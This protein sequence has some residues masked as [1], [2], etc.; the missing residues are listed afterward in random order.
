MVIVSEKDAPPEY[1]PI[2]P[3][4]PNVRRA[5]PSTSV[6][7]ATPPT[8]HLQTHSLHVQSQ[9][10]ALHAHQQQSRAPPSPAR[11]SYP[12]APVPLYTRHANI[13]S[14][15]PGILLRVVYAGFPQPDSDPTFKHLRQTLLWLAMTL[16]AVSRSF[17]LASMHVLRSS[18]LPAYTACVRKLYS[19]DP[20]PQ[21]LMIAGTCDDISKVGAGTVDHR[22]T[23]ILDRWLLLKVR[24]DVLADE[25]EL[26]LDL[27]ASRDV[28]DMHQPRARLEDLVREYG[29][30]LGVVS[31]GRSAGPGVYPFSALSVVFEPRRVLLQLAASGGRRLVVAEV[32]RARD[33]TLESSAKILVQHLAR[34]QRAGHVI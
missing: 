4:H 26:H 3:S 7:Q 33:E 6:R 15:P 11:S 18:Y 2:D 13:T 5:A 32:P 34:L 24:D 23:A 10:A 14:L 8:T 17:W 25:S 29:V 9:L 19:S 12:H 28:F 16:R 30:P 31:T 20:F 1:S 22:E 21:S 27:D